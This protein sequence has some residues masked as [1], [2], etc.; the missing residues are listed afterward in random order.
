MII[1]N[2]FI[3]QKIINQNIIAYK[4][5]E[6]MFGILAIIITIVLKKSLVK[7]LINILLYNI[8]QIINNVFIVVDNM[9][10]LNKKKTNIVAIIIIVLIMN[11]NIYYMINK[12]LIINV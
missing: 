7:M 2:I 3:S 5:V 9:F 1:I 6:N 10:G 4:T 11:N 8:I 12:L